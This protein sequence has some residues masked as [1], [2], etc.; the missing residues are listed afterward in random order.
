M[1]LTGSGTIADVRVKL[2]LLQWAACHLRLARRAI[3]NE[4]EDKMKKVAVI[5]VACLLIVSFLLVGCGSSTKTEIQESPQTTLGQ[6]LMDL[7]K[8]HKE[9]VISDDEYKKMKKEIMERYED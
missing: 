9:G 2:Q 6:E 8:A 7:D 5:A 4:E 1:L 3:I